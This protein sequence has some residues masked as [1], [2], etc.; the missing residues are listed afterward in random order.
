MEYTEKTKNE[1]AAE[2]MQ[3]LTQQNMA[4]LLLGS[5]VTRIMAT[6]RANKHPQD[7]EFVRELLQR[8]YETCDGRE[9]DMSLFRNCVE[10]GFY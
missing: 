2:Q 7:V 5:R 4:L 10:R 6:C 9:E 1:Q 3:G 8:L